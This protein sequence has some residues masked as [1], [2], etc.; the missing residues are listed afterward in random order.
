VLVVLVAVVNA[1]QVIVKPV[2]KLL[3]HHTRRSSFLLHSSL[4][5]ESRRNRFFV[6]S[7][8][9]CSLLG[10]GLALLGLNLHKEYKRSPERI[11]GLIVYM[12][13]CGM[14]RRAG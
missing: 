6:D 7:C 4:N 9:C 13:S 12:L 1:L 3:H 11:G 2:R 5:V 14:V 8:A 10:Y